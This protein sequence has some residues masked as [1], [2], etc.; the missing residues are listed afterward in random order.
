M[1]GCFRDAAGLRR[2]FAF[3]LLAL[4][5]FPCL[6]TLQ[7]QSSLPFGGLSGTVTDRTGAAI[8]G[9]KITLSSSDNATIRA[10]MSGPQGAFTVGNLQSGAYLVQITAPGFALYRDNLVGVAVGRE[11]RLIAELVPAETTEH[12]TVNARTE[13]ID[14]SQSSPVTNIDR[15]RIEELPIP[16][17]NY[18]NFTLLSPALANANP[19]LAR[20]SPSAPEGAFSAGGLR[21]SSNALSI[22][23]VDDDDE[24]TG[25]SRT[26]LSPEAI[27]DFQVVNHGYAAQSGGAAGGSVNVETRSGGKLQHGDA[28][29]F[30]QN[31]AL[32]GTPAL[33]LV[34]RKP[35]ESRL[36]AG[37]ATGGA[38]NRARLFYYIAA[39]QEIARGQ[40]ANDF[41]PQLADQIDSMLASSGPL[42]GF[43]LQQGFFP[44]INEETE[45][46][47][48]LDQGFDANSLMLRYSLA[49]SRS[50][51]DAFNFDDLA[52]ASARGSAFY[53][54][55]SING[56]WSHTFSPRLFNDVNFEL[57][58]RRVALQ[59]GSAASPGVVVAGIAELG[60]P[61]SGNNNRRYETHLDLGDG[62]IR[63]AGK[64]LVAA[65]FSEDHI[66]LRAA[67]R[68]GFRGIYVFPTLAA[69][70]NGQPDFYA[71]SFGDPDTNFGE[72]RTAAYVQDHWTPHPNFTLDYGLRYERNGL[73]NPLPQ[74]AFNLS[75]RFGFAWSPDRNWV[76]RGGF[77]T[78]FDRHLLSTV[79][80]IEEFNGIRAQLQVAEGAR[81]V[82]LYQSGHAFDAPQPDIA[83]TVW[84]A[85]PGMRNPY[86]ETASLGIEHALA[87]QW[88]VSGEY[89]FVHGVRMGRT[90]D[91]NLPAPVLLTTANAST[92]DVSSPTV[93]Q[94]GRLVFPPARLNPAFD[95]IN[96][97]QTEANSNYN[98]VTFTLNRQF[99][100]EFELLAGY[101]F[102][103]SIDDAS[104]DA[105]QPQNPYALRQERSPS[106]NDQRHRFVMSGLWAL[107]PDADDAQTRTKQA[108]TVLEKMANGL[109]LAPILTVSS[110]FPDNPLAGVDSSREHIYPFA[111]RPLGASRNSVQTPST[112][113]LDLRALKMVPIWRGHL[114]IVAESFNLLNHQN[115]E[116][117]N[118]VYGTELTPT[119][120]Y[121]R[122]IQVAEPRR[123]QFSLDFE[124]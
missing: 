28:F 114:D 65:G 60:T 122:P 99:T 70:G 115:V 118:S 83:P 106:L 21:P 48:R 45:V 25:L 38:V 68:D 58:Q 71:Q 78:F 116:Q 100:E 113:N 63:Q 94:L 67:D 18:L 16:S 55:N 102:S 96:E 31:G 62:V 110:G 24:Y 59:T 54:D 72:L 120:Q 52:D 14:T 53:D 103:K 79:N 35:D 3:S 43:R 97:F 15:D 29:L 8:A 95:A 41:D 81:A 87:F 80:R 123:L 44:T 40:E 9:A 57:A 109:E 19:A 93:Q 73:P 36:R 86:A 17:R 107:G 26:E 33:E 124:Y 27:S 92:L 112:V 66:A 64:H 108:R 51:N 69:F 90:I 10:V 91:S 119:A 22:D 76:V 42:R 101:T 1:L 75:P 98:G 12:V 20:Q 34:P 117:R 39:E 2:C 37:L 88:T 5:N 13:A 111:A 11:T 61:F 82:S 105:E 7:A 56:A 32:N 121:W 49:N 89:R 4:V 77:G 47:G 74:S 6:C 50:V 85:Q 23:G 104:N 30:A 84:Q 46:S